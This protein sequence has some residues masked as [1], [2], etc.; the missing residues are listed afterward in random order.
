MRRGGA[1]GL[2]ELGCGAGCEGASVGTVVVELGRGAGCEGASVGT[3]VV[4]AAMTA[5]AVVA[6]AGLSPRPLVEPALEGEV[7]WQQGLN[8]L[9]RMT[10]KTRRD[11]GRSHRPSDGG[12]G[13]WSNTVGIAS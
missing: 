4:A 5:V 10:L 11:I 6:T 1:V 7:A 2:V 13:F 8:L 3:V 9:V 12:L